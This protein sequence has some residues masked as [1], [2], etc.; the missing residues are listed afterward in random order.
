MGDLLLLLA[1]VTRTRT[2][3]DTGA[4]APPR[5]PGHEA[6]RLASLGAAAREPVRRGRAPRRAPDGGGPWRR[7]GARPA[8][9]PPA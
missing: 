6:D 5:V 2:P 1:A 4:G 8:T 9:A 7:F 3:S